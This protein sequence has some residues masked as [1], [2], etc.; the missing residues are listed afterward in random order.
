MAS[1]LYTA[2][3]AVGIPLIVIFAIY[4]MIMGYLDHK[5]RQ[6]Q[7]QDVKYF[8]A[9][10]HT[11]P[12]GRV[13]YSLISTS[14]GAWVV[15]S[16]ASYATYAGYVGLIS[17][18]VSAGIT[19]LIPAFI[20]PIIQRYS[21]AISLNDFVN[22]RFG[23]LSQYFVA[24][25][26]QYSMAVGMA[27]EYTAIGDLFEKIV[28]GDR[29]FIVV[30]VGVLTSIYTA[31]G[32]LAVSVRTDQVQGIFVIAMNVIFAIY[33]ASTFTLDTSIPLNEYLNAN[34]DG[35][36]SIAA[37]PLGLAGSVVFSEAFWQKA[38]VACNARDLKVASLIAA[39]V[40]TVIVFLFGFYGF[41][42]AWS[43]FYTDDPNLALFAV[44]QNNNNTSSQTGILV[45][46]C[47][48]CMVMN[49]SAVDSYQIGIVSSISSCFFKNYPLWVTQIV[50]FIINIPI[51]YVSLGGYGIINLFLS[52]NLITAAASLPLLLGLVKGM[53]KYYDAWN[54]FIGT[55]LS[56]FFAGLW[57]SL[58]QNS[59]ND[60]LNMVFYVCY[61]WQSFII[62]VLGSLAIV[63]IIS[64]V[65][66]LIA[67][68]LKGFFMIFWF[69]LKFFF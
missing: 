10:Q 59:V 28:G 53:E 50:V 26:C 21:D 13:A 11:Q 37:M 46:L 31:Y 66:Y 55:I 7:T 3:Y 68:V 33:I 58:D 1:D 39:V 24:L 64:L 36:A 5:K 15:F 60:G 17:Y 30:L 38:W 32:G 43:G 49:E 12:M 47:I 52:S 61:C 40:V 35:Y 4:A 62:V 65:R 41:I 45:I 19:I 27:A 6:N 54:L 20:G 29:I 42:A 51:I 16:P 56:L 48:L 69:Q 63:L 34:Q 14:L 2:V 44:F 22:R 9:A 25:L 18:S 23:L 8:I 57:G 67:T